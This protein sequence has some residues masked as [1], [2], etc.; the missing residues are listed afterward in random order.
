MNKQKLLNLL[1]LLITT[2]LMLVAAEFIFRRMIFSENKAFRNLQDAGKYATQYTD[3]YWKLVYLFGSPHPPPKQHIRCW[4]GK[5][6]S[7]P[8]ITFIRISKHQGIVERSC[9]M[10]IPLRCVWKE[11]N[12][13]RIS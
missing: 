11:P 5:D 12:A 9:C 6:I 13:F 2:G 8:K 10:A 7:I 3:D 1:L 4:V